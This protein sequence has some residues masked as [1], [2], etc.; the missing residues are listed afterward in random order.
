MK[1]R[2]FVFVLI[3][4][5]WAASAL[6]AAPEGGITSTKHHTIAPQSDK[7]LTD[8]DIAASARAAVDYILHLQADITED[9]ALNGD[10]DY[11]VLDPNDGGWDWYIDTF[12][13]TDIP[14][15][16]GNLYGVISNSIFRLYQVEP[17][18]RLWIGMTDAADWMVAHG[19]N[20]A[21]YDIDSGPDIVFLLDY[22]SQ[23]GVS[24]P[25][26]Y[27]DA[28]KAIWDSRKSENG[29]SVASFMT[30]L[31]NWANGAGQPP[32]AAW[33]AASYCE[34]LMELDTL[35]PGNGYGADAVAIANIIWEDSINESTTNF[36]AITR[37]V[38]YD[39]YPL[40]ISGLIRAFDTTDTHTTD[41]P[42]LQTLLLDCQYATTGGFSFNYGTATPGLEDY[43]NTAYAL[44]ALHDNLDMTS[45]A[46]LAAFQNGVGFLA[47]VQDPASGGF[48]YND[49]FH[50]PEEGA[51]CAAALVYGMDAVSV[52][53]TASGPDPITCGLSKTVTFAYNRNDATPGLR[54]YEI[55]FGLTDPNSAVTFALSDIADGG[56][57]ATVGSNYF[58]P[59]D[60]GDGSF[61]VND[62]ILGATAGLLVDGDLFTVVL[63]T[64]NDGPVDVNILSYKLRDPN[65]A[66]MYADMIGTSFV[67]DCTPPGP[68]TDITAAPAHNKVDVSWNPGVGPDTATY[69]I[70]RGLWYD[71]AINVSAYPEYN[72]QPGSTTPTRP[73]D[74]DAAAASGEWVL[75]GTVNVGTTTFTD[76]GEVDGSGTFDV[77]GANRGVY[78]Y[79]VF[80]VD[81]ATN[82]SLAAAANDRATNYWLADVV[83]APYTDLNPPS[84]PNGLVDVTDI[85]EL[86]TYF[87]STIALDGLGNNIDVGPTD[88]WSGFGIPTTDSVIDFE[89]LMIFAMNFGQ[90]SATKATDAN[91]DMITLAWVRHENGSYA[92][93]LIS[94]S[95]L[96]GVHLSAVGQ[97]SGVQAGALLKDQ[98]GQVF[99]TNVGS[100]LDAN[101]ALL[102]ANK[103]ISGSGDLIVLNANSL[104][105]PENLVIDLRGT[106][107]AKLDYTLDKTSGTVTPNVF[108]LDSNFPNPFNPMTK[109]SFSLPTAQDVMLA[110]YSVDGRKVATLLEGAQSAGT[111]EVLWMGRDDAGKSVASGTYFYQIKAGPYSQ[112]RKMTLIK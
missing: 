88:D 50:V 41:I 36:N 35:Y 27:Q 82:G 55:T 18:T 65:N 56:A 83:G 48:L 45:P 98:D 47:S 23:S 93:Q 59:V 69:E 95:G 68:V 109:I 86:G 31:F 51:E 13:H 102:G 89:D 34:G 79:E 99:M 60:N 6:A 96:Q 63:H 104:I 7:A 67:V 81:V 73:A 5:V 30:L 19:P 71:N 43:Q 37:P 78:Y 74:R 111:H 85:N 92:L 101:L 9:N 46:V 12:T 8:P 32:L 110:V 80:A 103:A 22:A 100:N 38:V 105:K 84:A 108:K 40:G 14:N 90:V 17:T 2:H 66:F 76:I 57:L 107:N 11:P 15:S 58:S 24:N 91:A 112:V 106:D 42:T 3:L 75:A 39:V 61:T 77:N 62:A 97:V 21:P 28:A 53:A 70:Y 87:G 64:A 20:V 4:T 16:W 29:G 26:V 33:D 72:D 52:A 10:P 94:G 44:W 1:A 25:S 54:G 49:G